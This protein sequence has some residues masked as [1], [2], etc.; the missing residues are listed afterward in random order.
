MG[1]PGPR[2]GLLITRSTCAASDGSGFCSRQPRE[3][4]GFDTMRCEP[5]STRRR[6][7]AMCL[8]A[9]HGR[10][11][12]CMIPYHVDLIDTCSNACSKMTH[13]RAQALRSLVLPTCTHWWYDAVYHNASTKLSPS[14]RPA[15]MHPPSFPLRSNTFGCCVPYCCKVCPTCHLTLSLAVRQLPTA[16]AGYIGT[17]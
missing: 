7:H 16:C 14:W 13:C 10:L 4:A 17:C 9:T 5:P 2:S 12:L 1:D 15:Q 6:C 8:K 3:A 11:Y